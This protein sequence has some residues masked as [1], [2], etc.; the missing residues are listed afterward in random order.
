MASNLALLSDCGWFGI[1]VYYSGFFGLYPVLARFVQ[2]DGLRIQSLGTIPFFS[3]WTKRHFQP[4][5]DRKLTMKVLIC[6]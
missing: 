5:T 4:Q 3:L 1:E 2:P 6:L